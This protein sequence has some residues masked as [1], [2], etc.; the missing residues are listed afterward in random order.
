MRGVVEA[1]YLNYSAYRHSSSQ[2]VTASLLPNR[3]AYWLGGG[4]TVTRS[5]RLG[6][7]RVPWPDRNRPLS[8]REPRHRGRFLAGRAQTS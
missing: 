1:T 4:G 8:V 2:P 7:K 6:L 5:P 3:T